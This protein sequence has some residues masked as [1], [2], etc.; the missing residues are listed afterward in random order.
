MQVSKHVFK[1]RVRVKGFRG[2]EEVLC[3][4]SM[5]KRRGGCE[6]WLLNTVTSTARIVRTDPDRG[7]AELQGLQSN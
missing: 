3:E 6:H 2:A 7:V 1:Q 4:F 5:I